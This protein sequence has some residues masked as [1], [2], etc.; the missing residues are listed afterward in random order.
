MKFSEEQHVKLCERLESLIGQELERYKA[1]KNYI[2]DVFTQNKRDQVGRK[3]A[4]QIINEVSHKLFPGD[5]Q[6]RKQFKRY[7]DTYF[8]LKGPYNWHHIKGEQNV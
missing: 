7:V 1:S 5:D 8:K 3:I 2:L 4:C 6:H